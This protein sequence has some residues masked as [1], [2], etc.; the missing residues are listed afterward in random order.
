MPRVRFRLPISIEV[1]DTQLEL[2]TSAAPFV[3]AIREN[4]PALLSV[5]DAGLAMGR[6]IDRAIRAEQAKR[7]PK[8]PRRKRV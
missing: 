6:A 1:T 7:P 5:K 4:A 2:L 3:R 8:K